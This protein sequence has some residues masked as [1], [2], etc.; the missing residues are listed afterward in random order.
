[1]CRLENGSGITMTT[2]DV[3]SRGTRIT[4][5]PP[6]EFLILAR[7]ENGAVMRLRTFTPDCDVDA[8]NMAVVWLT[9]VRADDSVAWLSDLIKS[10]GPQK[11][12]VSRVG[13]P[14]PA[15]R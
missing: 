7:V 11:E 1:M 13:D 9:D 5:E 10:A 15:A 8:G 3:Q 6:T 12:R 2:G 4:L 14:A